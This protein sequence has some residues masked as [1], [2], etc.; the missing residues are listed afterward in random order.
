MPRRSQADLM[1][2]HF[3]P[4][5]APP[6][7]PAYL[8]AKARRLWVEITKDRPPGFFRPGATEVLSTFNQA[9]VMLE[10]LW[11]QF[12]KVRDDQAAVARLTRQVC[13]LASLQMHLCGHLRLTPRAYV[14]RHAAQRDAQGDWDDDPL[15]KGRAW[16]E[17]QRKRDEG[18]DS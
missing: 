14:D 18:L 16:W 10:A 8:G 2:A 12:R 5:A 15:F 3:R 4:P 6:P 11:P 1:M 7:P 9:S 13:A 17:A